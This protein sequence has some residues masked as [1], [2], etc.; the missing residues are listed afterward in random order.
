MKRYASIV[1]I[2]GFIFGGGYYA[3]NKTST[4]EYVAPEVVVE[5]K[6]VQ[7]DALEKAVK[8]SQESKKAEIES[9]AKKAYDEAYT[10]EMKK[11]ELQVISEFSDKLD[12]RQ[13]ELEKETKEY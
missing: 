10:Q 3:L 7:V 9:I 13:I 8:D 11:V 4:V 12:A 5:E 2:V 6:E 1:I